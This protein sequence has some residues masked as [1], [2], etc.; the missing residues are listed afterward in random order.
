M[1]HRVCVLGG[2]SFGS[3]IARICATSVVSNGLEFER[4]IP[5]WVR[6]SELAA[7]INTSRTNT[8]YLPGAVL[9]TNLVATTDAASAV[10][11]ASLVIV[12]V[13]HEFFGET[14]T[15]AVASALRP[16]AVVLSLVKSLHFDASTGGLSLASTEISQLLGCSSAG[17]V[18]LARRLCVLMGPNL[19]KEML[20]DDGFAE[21]TIG[22]DDSTP[23]GRAA[24]ALVQRALSTPCFAT[25]PVA[26]R[27]AVE[28]CGALKNVVAIGVGFAD[29]SGHGA[30]TR[31][32]LI[33]V[34]LGE[35]SRF[36]ATFLGAETDD[37]AAR[38]P[39]FYGEACGLG[40]LVLTCTAGRGRLL[41][42]AFV[43][44]GGGG[45]DAGC[46]DARETV[47]MASAARWA[48][49]ENE[50]FDGM[51]LP[52]WHSVRAVQRVIAQHD[53][54]E[55]FPLFSAIAAVSFDGAPAS[56]V[57]DALRRAA[58]TTAPPPTAAAPLPLP[59]S[60]LRQ[61]TA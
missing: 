33:R 46:D 42:A 21:A 53:A 2:G 31:A 59:S 41:A 23:D 17:G 10:A 54:A 8:Q 60:S 22:Y 30:N 13:P 18:M 51:K 14:L 56:A 28:S 48:A 55:S 50:M 9:G 38:H 1:L 16:D 57:V 34:G 43:E 58:I 35:M 3:A 12:A 19:Y 20:D 45:D 44:R 32:A 37:G 7:E 36:A 24:A 4:Q 49:L 26:G 61:S 47:A 52:D 40:D 39:V 25:S 29:G 15:P 5:W 6:R 11:D 27:A